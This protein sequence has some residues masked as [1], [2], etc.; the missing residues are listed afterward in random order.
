MHGAVGQG[1]AAKQMAWGIGINTACQEEVEKT[2]SSAHPRT[3]E[4]GGVWTDGECQ[5]LK[6]VDLKISLEKVRRVKQWNTLFC[7]FINQPRMHIPLPLIECDSSSFSM[8]CL[9][10]L[11]LVN[12]DSQ[13]NVRLAAVCW[14]IL[15]PHCNNQW[16]MEALVLYEGKPNDM[17]SLLNMKHY[18]VEIWIFTLEAY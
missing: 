15:I 1:S 6:P 14:G 17:C 4:L 2:Y 9:R 11:S 13:C 18:R 10:S 5:L 3:R 8:Y 16:L 7:I 12:S